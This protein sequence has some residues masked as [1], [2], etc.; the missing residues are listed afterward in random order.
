MGEPTGRQLAI[1][2]GSL[3]LEICLPAEETL[4]QLLDE[5]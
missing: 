2:D 3:A 1:R 5:D 4:Y